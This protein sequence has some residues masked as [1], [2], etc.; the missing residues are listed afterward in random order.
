MSAE[1]GTA[2][3][4]VV[5]VQ[6]AEERRDALAVIDEVFREEKGW[7]AASERELP[8]DPAGAETTCWLLARAPGESGAEPVGVL[9]LV[10]DPSFELPE[11]LGLRLESGVDLQALARSG[12][13]AE[14]GR[15]MVRR[16]W[17]AR[18][19]VVIELMRAALAVA[20]ERGASHLLTAVFEGET[21]SPLDFHVRQLGFERI[22]S[23]ER[24]ELNCANRRILLRLDLRRA[25]E[26]L[27]RRRGVAAEVA[28]GLEERL[29]GGVAAAVA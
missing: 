4:E 7:I 8:A 1:R 13:H 5:V 18:P 9:R 17:R 22:G 29:A 26:R 27:G 20:L 28:R 19:R 15:M 6:N 21:H 14:V 3:I 2:R 11:S 23:H 10:F 12:R 16:A 25:F 24:G